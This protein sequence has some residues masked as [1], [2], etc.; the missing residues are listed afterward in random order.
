MVVVYTVT[1]WV[2]FICYSMSIYTVNHLVNIMDI[3]Y[4]VTNRVSFISYSMSMYIMYVMSDWVSIMDVMY[5]V[6]D[7]VSLISYSMSMYIVSNWM[8]CIVCNRMRIMM[9]LWVV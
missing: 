5:I 8:M 3:M 1:N 4:I 9:D 6:T 7:W 2:G